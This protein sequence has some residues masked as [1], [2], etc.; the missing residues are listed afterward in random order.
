LTELSA[1]FDRPRSARAV[2]LLESCGLLELALP[3]VWGTTADA[4]VARA[5]WHRA[6]ELLA[7][8]PNPPGLVLGLAALLDARR[9]AHSNDDAA[10]SKARDDAAIEIVRALRAS[11]AVQ[12]RLIESWKLVRA[13]EASLE[14]A[15]S[16]PRSERVR[17]MQSDAFASG[18]ALAAARATVD[19]RSPDRYAELARERARMSDAELFPAALAGAHELEEAKIPRGPAWGKLLRELETLQLDG[20]ISTRADATAWLAA[21]RPRDHEGG[22][23]PRKR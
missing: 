5:A 9:D 14:S 11:R 1:I 20:E 12:D 18:A 17:W 23:T 2:E 4:D 16:T 21:H 8:L 19:G 22:N 3:G 10:A 7:A 6:R 13:M 15:R